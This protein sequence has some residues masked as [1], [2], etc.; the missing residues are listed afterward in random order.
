[1]LPL[2]GEKTPEAKV[3]A[4]SSRHRRDCR[5]EACLARR[6]RSTRIT[7]V[8]IIHSKTS[9]SVIAGEASRAI[10]RGFY[11]GVPW[12]AATIAMLSENTQREFYGRGVPRPNN[13]MDTMRTALAGEACLAP[14]KPCGG[15]A[16]EAIYC[17]CAPHTNCDYS[18]QNIISVIAA[19][20]CIAFT[21]LII[22]MMFSMRYA[23][24]KCWCGAWGL[25]SNSRITFVFLH[26]RC[27]V[28]CLLLSWARSNFT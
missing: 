19:E 13:D 16:I 7:D 25:F 1:M 15:K 3:E 12:H 4:K 24:L 28:F 22:K 23:C 27:G 9:L 5:G 11:Y 8:A 6:V 2:R 26:V 20:A 17:P 10:R 21:R 14:T 18:F